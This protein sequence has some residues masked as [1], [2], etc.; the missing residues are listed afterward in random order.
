MYDISD[1]N[2]RSFSVFS[3]LGL[4]HENNLVNELGHND[5]NDLNL[6]FHS[7]SSH[8]VFTSLTVD[9]VR[10]YFIPSTVWLRI[11]ILGYFPR[12]VVFFSFCF[13]S[14]LLLCLRMK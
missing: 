10:F 13:L 8:S 5:L 2:F 7:L 3:S 12:S 6:F 1:G 11:T 9:S 4:G 14:Y